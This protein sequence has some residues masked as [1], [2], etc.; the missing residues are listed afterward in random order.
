MPS[1]LSTVF[2]LLFVCLSATA[3]DLGSA[4]STVS[5]L[6]IL[7]MVTPTTHAAQVDPTVLIDLSTDAENFYTAYTQVDSFNF[8]AA[9]VLAVASQPQGVEMTLIA[10]E[11]RLIDI[12]LDMET[13]LLDQ[14]SSY[15]SR[16]HE[17]ASLYPASF[18]SPLMSQASGVLLGYESLVSQDVLSVSQTQ[19]PITPGMSIK[20]GPAATS[21]PTSSSAT[22]TSK[23]SAAGST[24]TSKGAA[25]PAASANSQMIFNAAA[26]AVGVLGVAM[27]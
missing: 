17:S 1:L 19:G 11:S 10:D 27:M 25:A 9:L 4:N 15:M 21:S 22:E 12:Y 26:A 14:P 2:H 3:Q 8:E 6:G 18:S 5:D 24:S 13:S 16:L 23:A 7:Q 20:V